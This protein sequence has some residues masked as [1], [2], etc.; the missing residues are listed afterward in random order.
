[1]GQPVVHFEIGCRDSL[2]TQDFYA[3]LFGWK[4]AQAGPAAMI[5]TGSAVTG[6]I[7][8]LGHEPFHYTIF[9]V[10]VDDVQAYL[11][12]AAAL[13]GKTLVPPVPIPTGT[14]ALMQDPEG[15]TVGLWKPAA[16]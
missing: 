15:N 7:T 1:M 2:K 12:K 4:I 13:G 16:K 10:E 11:D 3:R 9:Y 5:D 8:A 14:F 6:H